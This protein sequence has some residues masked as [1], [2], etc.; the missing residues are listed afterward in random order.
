MHVCIFLLLKDIH[1]VAVNQ[2]IVVRLTH[3]ESA[4]IGELYDVCWYCHFARTP[5]RRST[6]EKRDLADCIKSCVLLSPR[7]PML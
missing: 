5:G 4:P 6:L 7:T 1:L 3:N 2:A